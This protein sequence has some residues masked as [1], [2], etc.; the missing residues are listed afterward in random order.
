MAL[1]LF[2]Y[3]FVK[4]SMF[5]WCFFRILLSFFFLFLPYVL[6]FPGPL[7]P[8]VPCS[9]R[10]LFH[11]PW[12]SSVPLTRL[13]S[14]EVAART[15]KGRSWSLGKLAQGLRLNPLVSTR[16][17]VRLHRVTDFRVFPPPTHTN[18]IAETSAHP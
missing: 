15:G 18:A 3:P 13:V 9:C 6:T 16:F 8:I 2:F 14:R 12:S 17:A 5:S 4:T 11:F 7:S 10:A 1:Q